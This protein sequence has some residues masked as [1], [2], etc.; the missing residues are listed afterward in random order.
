MV[1]AFITFS[2]STTPSITSKTLSSV[3][4]ANSIFF[5]PS[6]KSSAKESKTTWLFMLSIFRRVF[7]FRY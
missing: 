7:L 3:P 5:I 2:F 1:V 4:F 6:F